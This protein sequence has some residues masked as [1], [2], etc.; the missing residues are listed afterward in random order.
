MRNYA[1]SIQ[2]LIDFSKDAKV[3]VL[4]HKMDMI[5]EKDKAKVSSSS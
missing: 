3:F 5:P 1:N 2:A 4:V